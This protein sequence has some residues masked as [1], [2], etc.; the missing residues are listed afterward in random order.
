MDGEDTQRVSD[1][2]VDETEE[3]S[4]VPDPERNAEENDAD[5]VPTAD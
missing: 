3:G 4:P 1:Q 2:D 5:D